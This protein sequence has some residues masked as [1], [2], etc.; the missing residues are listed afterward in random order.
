MSHRLLLCLPFLLLISTPPVVLG[1]GTT[2]IAK[3]FRQRWTPPHSQKEVFCGFVTVANL[4]GA[5]TSYTLRLDAPVDTA[6]HQYD[7]NYNVSIAGGA[8]HDIVPGYG[9]SIFRLGCDGFVEGC[10][11]TGRVC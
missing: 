9:T 6:H 5:P 4:C 1:A 11:R 10:D 8:L 3:G 2:V 7:A